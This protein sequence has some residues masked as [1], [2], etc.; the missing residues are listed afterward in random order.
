M[1]VEGGLRDRLV[2]ESFARHVRDGLAARGWVDVVSG[3]RKPQFQFRTSPVPDAEEV[4]PNTIAVSFETVDMHDIEIGSNQTENSHSAWVD[5]YTDTT[6]PNGYALA[7]EVS[8]DV[9][10]MLAGKLSSIGYD[11]AGFPL[12]DVRDPDPEPVQL[13]WCDLEDI[14]QE[15][16]MNEKRSKRYWV[17]V[18]AQV[19]EARE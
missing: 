18:G 13:G 2:F 3:P 12:I 10:D 7:M 4:Q 11:A 15:R 8:G 19:V 16:S 14:V 9:R 5:I 6:D 1:T 17:A